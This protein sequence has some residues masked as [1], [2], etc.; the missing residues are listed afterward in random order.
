MSTD[1]TSNINT[2]PLVNQWVY[3][4]TTPNISF[5]AV[6]GTDYYVWMKSNS[7]NTYYDLSLTIQPA[8][9]TDDTPGTANL[10]SLSTT[11]QVFHDSLGGG[12]PADYYVF[13]LDQSE[14]VRLDLGGIAPGSNVRF[15]LADAPAGPGPILEIDQASSF[16]DVSVLLEAG[17]YSISLTDPSG[18]T[19]YDLTLALQPPDYAGNT[20]ATALVI[21]SLGPSLQ[22]F[23]D[24]LGAGDG[25]DIYNFTLN[26]S[27]NVNF[28]IGGLSTSSNVQ[29]GLYHTSSGQLVA[30]T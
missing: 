18:P 10:L 3:S 27:Q 25:V 4:N 23:D 16:S 26:S 15:T 2:Q 22:V 6:A 28:S 14:T 11:P 9:G 30:G 12:D 1:S 7:Q 17:T 19:T 5:D 13:T 20:F 21:P 29:L 8:D 24:W